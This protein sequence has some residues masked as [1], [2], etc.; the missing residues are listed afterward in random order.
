MLGNHDK[1]L[2]RNP[3]TPPP[4]CMG[5]QLGG[6]DWVW[7]EREDGSSHGSEIKS[8][9]FDGHDFRYA[10]QGSQL[11]NAGTTTTDG[12]AHNRLG[13]AVARSN[14]DESDTQK[15]PASDGDVPTSKH[16]LQ[17]STKR[18][19]G[20]KGQRVGDGDPCTDG[21]STYIFDHERHASRAKQQ[22]QL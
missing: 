21:A 19:D 20:S 5:A 22:G 18:V 1:D 8:S 6:I 7:S 3:E 10:S 9:L 15:K 12:H 16:I 14:D 11:S 4:S 17:V 2:Q 13:Y